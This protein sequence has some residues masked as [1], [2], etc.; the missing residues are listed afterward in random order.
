MHARLR[1]QQPVCELPCRSDIV[2]WRDGVAH[3]SGHGR[4]SAMHQVVMLP[5]RLLCAVS[6][7]R[8]RAPNAAKLH[9]FESGAG[10]SVPLR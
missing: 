5:A 8:V 9:E 7:R 6:V 3:N 4:R 10:T 2:A 1:R